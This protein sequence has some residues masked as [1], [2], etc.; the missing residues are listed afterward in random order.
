MQNY[1]IYTCVVRLVS[2]DATIAPNTS[3]PVDSGIL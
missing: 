2:G 3:V 1:M